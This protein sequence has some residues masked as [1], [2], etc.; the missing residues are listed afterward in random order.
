MRPRPSTARHAL[1]AVRLVNGAAGLLAPGL[2]LRGEHRRRA[3]RLVVA[4]HATD[5]IVSAVRWL[6]GDRPRRAALRAV[7]VSAVNTMLAVAALGHAERR[8]GYT[9]SAPMPPLH[10]GL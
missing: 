9:V 4:V 8:D 1:V 5:T 3:A 2:L 10:R 7:T 6:R